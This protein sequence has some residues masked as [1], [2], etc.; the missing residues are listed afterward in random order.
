LDGL[1]IAKARKEQYDLGIKRIEELKT[2]EKELA[3][4]YEKLESEMYL[5]EQFIRAKVTMLESKINS[6]FKLARF[7]LFDQ[8]I[9]GGLSECCET[10]YNGVPYMGGLNNGARINVG[11]DVINSLSEY[12]NFR[13][14]IFI[15]NRE[16]ITKLIDTKSQVISLIVSEKDKKLRIEVEEFKEA[17]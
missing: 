16:A 15:D 6:R 4:A 17:V 8:Q 13:A 12:Y 10:L 1:E 3:K 5:T 14:P 7:K 11:L 2:Q 9:N